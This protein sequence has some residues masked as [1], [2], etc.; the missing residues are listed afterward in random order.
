MACWS[1]DGRGVRACL[2][3]RNE[4]KRNFWKR[5]EVLV[6]SYS[7]DRESACVT[8]FGQLCARASFL[9]SSSFVHSAMH[10]CYCSPCRVA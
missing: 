9:K 5:A 4:G 3:V 1:R 10:D 8:R 6:I 2:F 7:S